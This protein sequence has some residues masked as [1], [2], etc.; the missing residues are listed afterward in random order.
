MYNLA[1][2]GFG[3]V[4]QGLLEILVNKRDWLKEQYGFEW[5]LV[6]ISD[7]VKG[8]KYNPDSL[9]AEKILGEVTSKGHIKD[10][11]APH[12]DWDSLKTIKESN[13]DIIIEVSYT[14]IKTGQPG[15]NHVEAAIDNG[16]HV[17]MTNKGPMVV[18]SA[19]L[20]KKSSTKGVL[21]R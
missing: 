15:L 21:L 7:I 20:L 6:A 14:N 5:K 13:A 18:A 10:I 3:V 11:K 4:G 19:D 8:S 9:D 12:S 2:V 16:K 17:A 1:F